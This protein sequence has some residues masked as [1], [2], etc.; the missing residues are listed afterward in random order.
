MEMQE[1]CHTTHFQEYFILILS[2]E[3]FERDFTL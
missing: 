1:C 3:S 2:Y